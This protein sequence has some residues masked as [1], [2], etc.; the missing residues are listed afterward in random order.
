MDWHGI[1]VRAFWVIFTMTFLGVAVWESRAP[2]RAW[3]VPTGKR[4][5]MHGLLFLVNASAARALLLRTTPLAV[6]VMVQGS[7]WG[8]LGRLPLWLSVPATVVAL[9]L[10][11]FFA[12]RLY[13][14]VPWLWRLHRVHHSD[15]D[16]DIATG[17]RFH[18][19]E[20]IFG[21]VVDIACVA[22]L[23]PPLAG[24]VLAGL[25]ATVV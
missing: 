7:S 1:Q 12:H 20:S 19:L 9:D 8:L 25:L 13:H 2:N 5:T 3:T 18:P 14:A 6:A 16:F 15:P 24:V 10:S 22:A 4:W 21:Q 23:A 17:L 11:K